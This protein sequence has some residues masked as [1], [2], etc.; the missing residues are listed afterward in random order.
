MKKSW[1]LVPLFLMGCA[2]N[3]ADNA[4]A[5]RVET[6]AAA[7][8]GAAPATSETAAPA[9]PAT[10]ASPAAAA[11]TSYAL[12]PA[13]SKLEW[14]GSKVTRSHDG[15]FRT[16]TGEVALVDGDPAKSS[17]RVEIQ[18]DSLFA[19]DPKLEGH[20][21]APD[22]FDVAKHP[23]A[24]FQST[25]IAKKGEDYEV[26]G[27]L[28][29]HGVT[30]S[31]TFPAEIKVEPDK[32]ET[33]AEFSINRKDWGIVYPGM[34]NDLIRDEVVLKFDVDATAPGT[35]ATSPAPDAATPAAGSTP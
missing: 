22:F 6:P 30:K 29:M 23:T 26:T 31:I 25:A 8:S 11:G 17:V 4:P 27:D 20:L 16:F 3:P 18:M 14:K 12:D 13:T 33:E 34:A 28:T 5:A 24:T 15:G 9:T 19:D 1:L 21:K 32:V 10:G 7:P 35:A 2:Q